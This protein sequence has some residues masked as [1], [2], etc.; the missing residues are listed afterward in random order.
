MRHINGVFDM[1][2]GVN[3]RSGPGGTDV[4]FERLMAC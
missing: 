2:D 4:H 1:Y 3:A